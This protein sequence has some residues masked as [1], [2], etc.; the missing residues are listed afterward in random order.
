M[1]EIGA[2][3]LPDA[4]HWRQRCD[5]H[6]CQLITVRPLDV[7]G[8]YDAM[9]CLKK[10][11]AQKDYRERLQR[12]MVNIAVDEVGRAGTKSGVPPRQTNYRDAILGDTILRL[13]EWSD[14]ATASDTCPRLARFKKEV[15][16]GLPLLRQMLNGDWQH[17]RVQHF[18]HS[19]DGRRCCRDSG[20]VADRVAHVVR[21]VVSG[22]LLSGVAE[23]TKT[24]WFSCAVLLRSVALCLACH[25]LL[26]RA[27]MVEFAW[28]KRDA[29]REQAQRM[30][31]DVNQGEQE[32]KDYQR[33]QRHAKVALF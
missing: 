15:I 10:L 1:F 14:E 11:L 19:H 7:R 29:L 5:V 27:W 4:L 12:R 13:M 16:D 32:H 20:E 18:C 33:R 17:P 26:Q 3:A 8:F 22:L 30:R 25:G 23:P 2:L 6:A 28:S 24:K 21:V 31:L 9:Y